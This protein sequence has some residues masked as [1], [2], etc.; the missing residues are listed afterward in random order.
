MAS[1]GTEIEIV[2]EEIDGSVDT[3][4]Y[5]KQRTEDDY[6]Q[7]NKKAFGYFRRGTYILE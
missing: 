1:R 4:D 7:A 3:E 2:Y 6:F 5:I